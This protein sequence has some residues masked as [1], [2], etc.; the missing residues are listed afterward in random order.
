MATKI[1][2]LEQDPETGD[3]VLPLDDDIFE[4]A[5]WKIGDV[6]EWIDNE[7]GSWTMRKKENA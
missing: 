3:L 1:V 4:S 2:T 7:D 5:G 6:I